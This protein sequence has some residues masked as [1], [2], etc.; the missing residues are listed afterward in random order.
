MKKII[1]E[2][3]MVKLERKIPCGIQQLKGNKEIYGVKQKWPFSVLPS[4]LIGDHSVGRECSLEMMEEKR[5]HIIPGSFLLRQRG[6]RIDRGP[7]GH[8]GSLRPST[9]AVVG[10]KRSSGRWVRRDTSTA[11]RGRKSYIKTRWGA[12]PFVGLGSPLA[13]SILLLVYIRTFV[14]VFLQ[15]SLHR[16]EADEDGSKSEPSLFPSSGC[17]A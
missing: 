7:G 15:T 17:G 3:D 2:D 10:S 8:W 16:L 13:I 1:N 6:R 4:W 14:Y 5:V 12:G 11:I 9:V